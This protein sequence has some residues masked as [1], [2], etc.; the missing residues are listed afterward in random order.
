VALGDGEGH[1]TGAADELDQV[2]LISVGAIM[3]LV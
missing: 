2:V 3:D 1:E